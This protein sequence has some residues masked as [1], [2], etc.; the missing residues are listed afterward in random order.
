MTK[1][2][3]NCFSISISQWH[4]GPVFTILHNLNW[5]KRIAWHWHITPRLWARVDR[6]TAVLP[7]ARYK[8]YSILLDEPFLMRI[9]SGFQKGVLQPFWCHLSKQKGLSQHVPGSNTG[10]NAKRLLHV[11]VAWR[12][13][14]W[15]SLPVML[16]QACDS[17]VFTSCSFHFRCFSPPVLSSLREM[18]LIV[19]QLTDLSS[20][21]PSFLGWEKTP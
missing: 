7:M 17:A 10:Q 6:L 21:K 5:I 19:I 16:Y 20:L 12:L 18:Q 2:W 13:W 14:C 8:L 11:F 4:N 15:V 1:Q 9:T 3:T